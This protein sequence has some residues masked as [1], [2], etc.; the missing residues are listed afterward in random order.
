MKKPD[1]GLLRPLFQREVFAML[2]LSTELLEDLAN[3]VL[4]DYFGTDHFPIHPVEIEL[5]ARHYLR[6]NIQHDNLCYGDEIVYGVTA[7]A[8]SRIGFPEK[9]PV[10]FKTIR[11]DTILLDNSLKDPTRAPQRAFTI[12]HEC[13]HH[14]IAML[15]PEYI[16]K[17]ET[18]DF[19]KPRCLEKPRDWNE[20]QA[21]VLASVLLMPRYLVECMQSIVQ[22][23]QKYVIYDDKNVLDDERAAIKALATSLGVS[24]SAM[25]YRLK[26]LDLV[27]QKSYLEY[28]Y[29][30]D[31]AHRREGLTF[32]PLFNRPC[33]LYQNPWGARPAEKGIY[34]DS[35][36]SE[37]LPLL[38]T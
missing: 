8:D 31:A 16:T 28:I 14:I 13:A 22:H 24:Y 37:D 15:K 21:N 1:A 12:A 23:P 27:I 3:Q 17:D 5:F 30:A 11:Q 18:H 32:E 34:V 36:G 9:N 10:I 6:L 26:R 19:C 7:Y 38:S 35:Y 29:E 25:L 33:I 2:A 20:W 4:T